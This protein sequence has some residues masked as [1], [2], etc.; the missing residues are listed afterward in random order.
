[1]NNVPGIELAVEVDGAQIPVSFCRLRD[2]NAR[3][4]TASPPVVLLGDNKGTIT[5]ANNGTDKDK[6]K[7]ID[8][9]VSTLP[10]WLVNAAKG[11]PASSTASAFLAQKQKIHRVSALSKNLHPTCPSLRGIQSG[12]GG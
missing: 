12:S 2:L 8:V 7:H 6:S 10:A 5:A 1:M 9:C 3:S 4:G 11:L